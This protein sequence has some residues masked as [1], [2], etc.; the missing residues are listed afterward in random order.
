MKQLRFATTLILLSAFAGCGNDGVADE[1]SARI[2]Y[3]GLD[4]SIDR[5]MTLGF[6]G[7][8]EASSANIS[9]QSDKGAL[10]GTMDVDGKVDQ[11]ASKNKNM[12]LNV[13]LTG[14]AD[15]PV[16][17]LDITYDTLNG[18]ILLGLSLKG[19]P[20][21]NF[22][23]SFAGTPTMTG[24]LLGPVTLDLS[25]SGQTEEVPDAPGD[26]RRKSGTLRITGTATSDFGTY[27]VD[28]SR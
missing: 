2:A 28:I 9:K 7:F 10:R 25:L 18:P 1:E 27:N 6:D 8:N 3:L 24:A 5:A 12:D 26:V 22:T 14:Y 19:L 20:D 21:A 16:E 11:G 23:G 15:A 13:V 4:A 17:E